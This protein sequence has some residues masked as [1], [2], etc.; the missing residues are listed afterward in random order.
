MADA[1]TII[2]AET[3]PSGGGSVQGAYD[4]GRADQQLKVYVDG[5]SNSSSVDIE[6][7]AQPDE[8]SSWFFIQGTDKKGID[9]TATDDNAEVFAPDYQ[10]ADMV[11]VKI[12]NNA[13]SDTT[14]TVKV[15][16]FQVV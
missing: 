5:D 2:D 3:V 10:P 11:R 1:T 7:Y 6:F 14:V 9:I 12:T 15:K 16:R 4:L 8:M 13:S